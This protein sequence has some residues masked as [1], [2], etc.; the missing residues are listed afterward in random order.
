MVVALGHT[1]ANNAQ[2]DAAIRS[3]AKMCTH[4]GNGS[5]GMMPRHDNIIQ[6]LLARDELVACFIPDGIHLPPVL[7]Q[8]GRS[9]SGQAQAPDRP[10][11]RRDRRGGRASP[12]PFYIQSG[13]RTVRV[14]RD[15]RGLIEFPGHPGYFF[16]SSL[17]L[18]V[19]VANV[20][21]WTEF[22]EAVAWDWASRRP[23]EIVGIRLPRIAVPA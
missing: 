14:V 3:G 6:R 15:R 7:G 4:L 9:P 17:T 19:G 10:H 13:K 12:G 1:N 8:A 16:G 5:L 18:D 23:A 21:R 20:A 2:I 11:H 22:S